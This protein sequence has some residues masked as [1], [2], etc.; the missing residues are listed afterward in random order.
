MWS[1]THLLLMMEIQTVVILVVWCRA[2]VNESHFQHKICQTLNRHI[3]T[4]IF[5]YFK[6]MWPNRACTMPFCHA[7]LLYIV[8]WTL[9]IEHVYIYNSNIL[10]KT[11]IKSNEN[12]A[13]KNTKSQRKTYQLIV[14]HWST[15]YYFVL[16]RL[17]IKS[18]IYRKHMLLQSILWFVHSFGGLRQEIHT[19]RACT[20]RFTLSY[21][22]SNKMSVSQQRKRKA[23][24]ESKDT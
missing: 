2:Y 1:R 20:C 21:N 18:F 4:L 10:S 7:I 17:Y 3:S 15:L 5:T 12:L 13:P 11:F 9:N 16:L 23:A 14:Y 19:K 8:H 24:E 6:S 22:T